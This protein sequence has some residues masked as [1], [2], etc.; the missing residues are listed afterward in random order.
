MLKI[1]FELH[2]TL[3][4]QLWQSFDIESFVI[5]KDVTSSMA[6]FVMSCMLEIA[7]FPFAFFLTLLLFNWFSAFTYTMRFYIL[8]QIA[9]LLL[10]FF[11][12]C[13]FSKNLRCIQ[14]YWDVDNNVL[15]VFISLVTCKRRHLKS[16][17]FFHICLAEVFSLFPL[18]HQYTLD[19]PWKYIRSHFNSSHNWPF[20]WEQSVVNV[21]LRGNLH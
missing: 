16:F 20:V 15:N 13:I 4:W 11:S 5:V 6:V 2:S 17:F 7:L 8:A 1:F 9:K 19:F 18:L 14:W 12:K 3:F 21:K 10:D